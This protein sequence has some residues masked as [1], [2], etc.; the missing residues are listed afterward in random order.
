LVPTPTNIMSPR[1]RAG[2]QVAPL[3]AA[4]SSEATAYSLVVEVQPATQKASAPSPPDEGSPV[5]VGAPPLPRDDP[6]ILSVPQPAST[7]PSPAREKEL[8]RSRLVRAK[9]EGRKRRLRIQ[10]PTLVVGS[11][12][13][14]V[15]FVLGVVVQF[16]VTGGVPTAVSTASIQVGILFL[17]L[18][19]LPSLPV[20]TDV[21]M[22]VCCVMFVCGF[23]VLSF[24]AS[25][26][27]GSCTCTADETGCDDD[28]AACR[29]A[30]VDGCA[31]ALNAA[32]Y[33]ALF[34][35]LVISFV[36]RRTAR[37]KVD[38]I[39]LSLG[40]MYAVPTAS[41]LLVRIPAGVSL[42]QVAMQTSEGYGLVFLGV[43]QGILSC[44]SFS[45]SFRLHVHAWLAAQGETI[46]EAATVAALLGGRSVDAVLATSS[47]LFRGMPAASI[48]YPHF[49]V[50]I[51][52][53]SLHALT[54]RAKLGG[55][56][57]FLSH[58]WHDAPADKYRRLQIWRAAFVRKHRREPIVWF[59]KCCIDQKNIALNLSSLPVFLAG[60][61]SLLVLCGPTYLSRLWCL[62]ELFVFL[63][64]GG[65]VDQVEIIF[66]NDVDYLSTTENLDARSAG[67]SHPNDRERLLSTIEAGFGGVE[68]FNVMLKQRLRQIYKNTPG[69][70]GGEQTL[71]DDGS[72]GASDADKAH[73]ASSQGSWNKPSSETLGVD[74]GSGI[75]HGSKT[76]PTV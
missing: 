62:I 75:G 10:V 73:G 61:K 56:D 71:A 33:L 68:T 7:S 27:F 41:I 31:F 53:P 72:S 65:G 26:R 8:I 36:W 59:D 76:P 60:C 6:E 23:V 40:W 42:G 57:V 30:L 38:Q 20:F 14:L 29:Y 11:A 18:T 1:G 5:W 46:H 43:L 17:V 13:I 63:E 51:V 22:V 52:D 64:M 47:T 37:A 58:S 15:G 69:G 25:S 35:R 16:G 74:V 70:G 49:S 54:S 9:L 21:A 12:F 28:D 45:R 50:N 19:V 48:T 3:N 2:A 4:P 39:W 66:T 55:V 32:V 24:L 44:L 67:C 34:C